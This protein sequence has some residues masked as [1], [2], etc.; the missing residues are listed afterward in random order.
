MQALTLHPLPMTVDHVSTLLGEWLSERVTYKL[1]PSVDAFASHTIQICGNH[2]GVIG[3]VLSELARCIEHTQVPLQL[4]TWSRRSHTILPKALASRDT[5]ARLLLAFR[6][7]GD[8]SLSLIERVRQITFYS[9]LALPITLQGVRQGLTT[10]LHMPSYLP[11]CIRQ[12]GLC[13]SVLGDVDYIVNGF[14]R[15][16]APDMPF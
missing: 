3:F 4:R 2:P 10:A 14:Q 11:C 8:G 9:F 12:I 15:F 1:L 7:L 13:C 6:T 5:Y 16:Q